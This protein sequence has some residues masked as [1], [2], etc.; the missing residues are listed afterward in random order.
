MT[1]KFALSLARNVIGQRSRCALSLNTSVRSDPD[2]RFICVIE[3]RH[4]SALDAGMES[5]EADNSV[6]AGSRNVRPGHLSIKLNPEATSDGD[7]WK[8]KIR[9]KSK[10]F[11]RDVSED[12]G[13]ISGEKAKMILLSMG[14]EPFENPDEDWAEYDRI[15]DRFGEEPL[16]EVPTDPFAAAATPSH[17][18]GPSPV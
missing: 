7:L 18:H 11:N 13:S 15:C 12:I 16:Q 3:A 6:A 14:R 9:K 8:L 5:V 2:Y 1:G 17:D 10:F 4:A